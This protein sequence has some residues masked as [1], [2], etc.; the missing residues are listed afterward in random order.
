MLQK[1]V[2]CV[3]LPTS[4]K[5]GQEATCPSSAL[6]STAHTCRYL[7]TTVCAMT[8]FCSFS[9]NTSKNSIF[10]R[11]VAVRMRPA[12]SAPAASASSSA[13]IVSH[14]FAAAIRSFARSFSC[15]R[16]WRT[17]QLSLHGCFKYN[18]FKHTDNLKCSQ[19]YGKR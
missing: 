10:R 11:S 17:Q 4:E 18:D 6:S 14:C 3:F 15:T 16:K 2:S 7:C 12:E 5:Q 13:A 19:M 8:S 1:S 9:I